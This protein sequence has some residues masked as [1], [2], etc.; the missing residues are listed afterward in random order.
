MAKKFSAKFRRFNLETHRDFGFFFSA[1]IIIYSI[2]GIALNHVNEWNA[3]FII[4]KKE[5][6]IDTGLTRETLSEKKMMKYSLLVDEDHFKLYD[7]PT[8]DQVKIYYDNATLH[9]NL[10]DGTGKYEKI[11]R[12]PFIYETN[13]IHKN[14][15]KGWKWVSDIF[16]VMLI[17]ITVTGMFIVKGKYGISGRGK[18]YVIAGTVLPIIAVILASIFS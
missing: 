14:G 13:L 12:R 7:Y 1:L 15:I 17:F 8:K 5:I 4:K 6:K 10:T 11:S 9:L 2:S 16:A 18:W 3:D